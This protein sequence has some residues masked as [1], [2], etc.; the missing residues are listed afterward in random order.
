MGQLTGLQAFLDDDVLDGDSTELAYQE[1]MVE[2]QLLGRAASRF[3]KEGGFVSPGYEATPLRPPTWRRWR[4]S[5]AASR[6]RSWS[7]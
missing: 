5:S 4:S 7:Y 2:E 6:R 1:L 3:V